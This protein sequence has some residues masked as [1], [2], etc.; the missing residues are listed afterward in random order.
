MVNK[1]EEL[2][3]NELIQI[4]REIA[5][6]DLSFSEHDVKQIISKFIEESGIRD[7]TPE[8]FEEKRIQII[9]K[10]NNNKDQLKKD[11]FAELVKAF[12]NSL[13]QT[14]RH[15]RSTKEIKN[16]INWMSAI[17]AG[18]LIWLITNADKFIALNGRP[19]MVALSDMPIYLFV[20]LL[21]CMSTLLLFTSFLLIHFR[22]Y[23]LATLYDH[24]SD[25]IPSKIKLG[26]LNPELGHQRALDAAET[27]RIIH[28]ISPHRIIF[29][30]VVTYILGLIAL[31]V[32][33]ISIYVK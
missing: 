6:P 15:R 19:Y 23:G 30:G 25:S 9:N 5:G 20:N 18:S 32:F 14:D 7:L 17:S 1:N 31:G 24:L 21:F 8:E 28:N 16:I 29:M 4:C 11:L 13:E 22:N 27:W 12:S 2:L 10:F 33:I 26:S 3:T